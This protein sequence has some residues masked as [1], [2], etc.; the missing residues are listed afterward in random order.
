[1]D[2]PTLIHTPSGGIEEDEVKLYLHIGTEKTGTTSVQ[3]F[4]RA[5]RDAL[6][7]AGILYPSAPGNQNH[8]GLA[9]AAQG[10]KKQGP[11]R[12]SLGIKTEEDARNH[13]REMM[14]GLAAEL[15]GGRYHTAVMSGEHCSSRLIEDEEVGWLKDRLAPF[16]DGMAIVVYIRRQDDYLLSTYSTA[17]KS[18]ATA[19]L[20]MP[21]EKQIQFRYDHW[22]MLSRWARVFGREN[23]ICRRFER[24]SLK[25]GDIVDDILDACAIQPSADYVRPEDVN[26]SLDAQSLEFLRLF[27]N[28]IPRFEDGDINPSRDNIV[29]LLSKTSHGPLITLPPQELAGFMAQFAES[30]RKVAMEYFGGVRSGGDDPLFAPPSDKRARTES[31]ELSIERAVEIAAGL[32]QEKQA[33]VER[34]AERAKRRRDALGL[35]RQRRRRDKESLES[36]EL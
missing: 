20:S 18:G 23:V 28:H 13:R 3:K 4:F 32:W 8:Q 12:K 14:K 15:T 24:A 2:S 34:V 26:E 21:R 33:Q 5:N 11:L 36:E 6:A 9:A 31:A 27:N 30:N 35:E 7:R 16:F 29:S 10:L 17:V 22:E 19:P 1:M 25:N